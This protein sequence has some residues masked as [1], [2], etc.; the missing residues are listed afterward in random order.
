MLNQAKDNRRV[1]RTVESMIASGGDPR[2][3]IQRCSSPTGQLVLRTTFGELLFPT[4]D[5][6]WP[7]EMNVNLTLPQSQKER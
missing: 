4:G 3:W 5:A 2:S 6:A 7:E 1:H